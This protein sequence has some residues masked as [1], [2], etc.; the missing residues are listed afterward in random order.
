MIVGGIDGDN[1]ADAAQAGDEG[2]DGAANITWDLG[3]REVALWSGGGWREER[4]ERPPD[5]GARKFG[6]EFDGLKDYPAIVLL[7]QFYPLLR[8][9]WAV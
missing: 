6:A 5:G 9:R 1:F 3:I 8:K 7:F 2:S 4:E